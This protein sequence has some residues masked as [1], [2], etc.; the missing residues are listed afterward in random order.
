MVQG[1]YFTALGTN[2]DLDFYEKS[3]A[4]HFELKI[5]GRIGEGRSGPNESRF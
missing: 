4:T 1:D 2:E 5:R 3:S